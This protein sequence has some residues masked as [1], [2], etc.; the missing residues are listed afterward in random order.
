MS[1][2]DVYGH[3]A[4]SIVKD[5]QF[6]GKDPYGDPAGLIRADNISHGRQRKLV[7]HAFSD[8][9]LKE[10]EKML[11]NYVVLL[12]EKLNEVYTKGAVNMVEWYN[13]TTFDVCIT[14]SVG[15][16]VLTLLFLFRSW[17]I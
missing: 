10:Q 15:Q 17:L 5:S 4:T 11:K 9:A 6:Y 3:R 2:K 12:I 8:K 16:H 13:F 14:C 1:R 7:S